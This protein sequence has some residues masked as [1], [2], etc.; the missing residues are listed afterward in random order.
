MR[1]LTDDYR[2]L[3]LLMLGPFERRPRGGWRFGTKVISDRKVARLVA[4][5]HAQASESRVILVDGVR[6]RRR[7]P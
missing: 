7:I 2:I 6:R 5:G 4:S 1:L 3:R